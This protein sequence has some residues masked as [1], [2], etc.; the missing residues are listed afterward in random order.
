MG[1][2]TGTRYSRSSSSSSPTSW[3]VSPTIPDSS[4][5][6]SGTADAAAAATVAAEASCLPPPPGLVRGVRGRRLS[7]CSHAGASG[8]SDPARGAAAERGEDAGEEDADGRRTRWC[9]RASG[10]AECTDASH[11]WHRNA[12]SAGQC[13]RA[14]AA[15]TR[16]TPAP[17]APPAPRPSPRRRSPFRR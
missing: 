13:H 2:N 16:R 14:A 7:P 9:R 6:R 11:A 1:S 10:F 4:A 17:C 15:C 3:S 12:S 8:S 5:S